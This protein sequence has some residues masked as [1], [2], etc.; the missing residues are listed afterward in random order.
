MV[1][2]GDEGWFATADGIGDGSYAYSGGE[3][4]GEGVDF[5][6]NLG[7]DTLD[8]V[9]RILFLLPFYYSIQYLHSTGH[10]PSLSIILGLQLHLGLNLDPRA[11][12]RREGAQEACRA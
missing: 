1:T 2:L 8:Y 9:S 12:R 6:K 4:S 5:V 11:Q 3:S 10:L 7:I